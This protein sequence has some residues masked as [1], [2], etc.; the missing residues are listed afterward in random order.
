[1][2]AAIYSKT[3]TSRFALIIE[4]DVKIPFDI[5]FQA[6]TETAPK[7]F[8]ILQ[9]FNSNKVTMLHTWKQ[10]INNRNVLW[11]SK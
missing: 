3:A 6:L 11:H 5:D 1:M 9:L 7:G 10:Y 8:G 4:D 2:R